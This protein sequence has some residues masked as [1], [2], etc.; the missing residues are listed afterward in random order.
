M[1]LVDSHQRSNRI[2]SWEDGLVICIG[3]TYVIPLLNPLQ[4]NEQSLISETYIVPTR[5]KSTAILPEKSIVVA[6]TTTIT[7]NAT[8]ISRNERET[9]QVVRVIDG[10]TIEV[11]LNGEEYKVRYIGID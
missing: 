11:M 10:D 8:E 6:E 4:G 9:A 7:A 3:L 5:E 2:L 1:M